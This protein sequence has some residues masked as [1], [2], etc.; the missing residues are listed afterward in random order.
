MV[1]IRRLPVETKSIHVKSGQVEKCTFVFFAHFE[2]M[3]HRMSKAESQPLQG[4]PIPFK[5]GTNG[6]GID[7]RAPNLFGCT[8]ERDDVEV[9]TRECKCPEVAE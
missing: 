8:P 6:I 7:W 2:A 5:L 9:H 1:V 4:P 3:P